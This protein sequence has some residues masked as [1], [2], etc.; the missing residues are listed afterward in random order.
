MK[1]NLEKLKEIINNNTLTIEQRHAKVFYDGLAQEMREETGCH[2][3][4]EDSSN[5]SE[6]LDFYNVMVKE[7]RRLKS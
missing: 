1:T 5:Y 4:P 7:Y 3:T 6:L 2:Y